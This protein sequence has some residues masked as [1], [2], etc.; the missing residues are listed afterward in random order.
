MAATIE[1]QGADEPEPTRRSRLGNSTR[2]LSALRYPQ[3]RRFWLGNLA[4][5]SSQQ[6]I[7]VA[8][9]WLV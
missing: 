7:R 8:Q 3:Y 6:I 9:G 2:M 5:V 4:A 1:P